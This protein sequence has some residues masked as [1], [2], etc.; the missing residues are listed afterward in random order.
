MSYA[1]PIPPRRTLDQYNKLAKDLRRAPETTI[2]EWSNRLP[3]GDAESIR[4]LW[5]EFKK[6]DEPCKL[7]H[8]QLFIA[9]THGFSSWPKFAN[10]LTALSWLNS[11]VAN[12]EA[13]ADAV[14]SG[15]AVSL[16][17][18][19][20][21]QPEL[22]QARSTFAHRST[23]LHYVSANGIEDFRQKTPANIVKIT[24]LLL[25]AGAD[26]NAES[27]A[28]GGH[29]TALLLTATSVYPEQAGVQ[30]RLLKILIDHG[31]TIDQGIVNACLHN[32]RGQAAEFLANHGA[33]LEIEGTAGVG[34]LDLVKALH[35]AATGEQVKDAFA[36][37]CQ[38]GRTEVVDFLLRHGVAVDAKLKHNGQTG[39]HW[40]AYG[41]HKATVQLLLDRGAPTGVKDDTYD[42]S[43]LDWAKHG[44]TNDEVIA[45]LNRAGAPAHELSPPPKRKAKR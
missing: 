21:D 15:N 45:L 33:P 28:Y 27:E 43:P 29:S 25:D 39:L 3:K 24:K 42:G 8:A 40:A 20:G 37:A 38:F 23:L 19:L 16:K 10:H 31:A 12:F 18:R 1:L 4:H 2:A 34:R 6:P 22:A 32:G 13:A 36:W 11:P 17:K 14:V 7:A 9:R 44:S 41:G 35:P 30:D 26:V 5:I